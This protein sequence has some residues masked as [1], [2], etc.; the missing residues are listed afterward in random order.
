M[1]NLGLYGMVWAMCAMVDELGWLVGG[2]V[3]FWGDVL[4]G[5][6]SSWSLVLGA[7][8]ERLWDIFYLFL[9]F[10]SPWLKGSST[11]KRLA[12]CTSSISL[13]TSDI[14]HP[15]TPPKSC[16]FAFLSFYSPCCVFHFDCWRP[17]IAMRWHRVTF[18]ILI[19]RRCP[20]FAMFSH[21]VPMEFNNNSTLTHICPT[22][23]AKNST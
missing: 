5:L 14:F 3:A 20:T 9:T 17:C 1:S 4:V 19:A 23:L 7:F 18:F 8:H 2:L 21:F 11:L 15:C 13:C 22:D 12:I 10:F 16:Y 6:S